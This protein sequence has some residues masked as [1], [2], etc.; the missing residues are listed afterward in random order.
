MTQVPKAMK[1]G[2]GSDERGQPQSRAVVTVI[3][4]QLTL[5][6]D[7]SCACAAIDRKTARYNKVV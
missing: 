7:Y 3:C 2:M 4:I 6:P 1:N 5:Y